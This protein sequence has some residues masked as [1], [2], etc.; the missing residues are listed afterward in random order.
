MHL[1]PERYYIKILRH[2]VGHTFVYLVS[3]VLRVNVT[4][5]LVEIWSRLGVVLT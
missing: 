5:D 1:S 4:G 2:D 3:I